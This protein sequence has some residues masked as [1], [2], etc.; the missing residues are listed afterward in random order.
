[1]AAMAADPAGMQAAES[2]NHGRNHTDKAGDTGERMQNRLDSC[3]IP[4]S[5]TRFMRTLYCLAVRTDR[6]PEILVKMK[7][8]NAQ[9]SSGVSDFN[10]PAAIPNPI[11]M[12]RSLA[13]GVKRVSKRWGY[14]A[15][16]KSS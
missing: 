4:K 9:K 5:A 8:R 13:R 10:C 2:R 15:A 14:T 16:A 1:M 7:N 12:K 6:A 3:A 11:P